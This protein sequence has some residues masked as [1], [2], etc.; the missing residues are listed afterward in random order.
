M[1]EFKKEGNS[2]ICTMTEEIVASKIPE[3]RNV[4][5]S[6][7][8]YNQDWNE[9]IFD[10]QKVKTLDSIGVN[11]VVGAFKKASSANRQ[12]KVVGCNEPVTKVL[13]L[14]K[15]DEKFTINSE[16]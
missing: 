5:A 16:A 12:F 6:Y 14:F 4:L 11:F 7:L 3:M 15:L 13:K 8:D 10:C 9:L 1:I 2:L